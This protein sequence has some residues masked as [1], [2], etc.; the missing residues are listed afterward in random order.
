MDSKSMDDNGSQ[1]SGLEKEPFLLND[2][3][4][5]HRQ[6]A[7]SSTLLMAVWLASHII[8]SAILGTVFVLN[9]KANFREAGFLDKDRA[10]ANIPA[11]FG[12]LPVRHDNSKGP[13]VTCQSTG[14]PEAARQAG[15]RFDLFVNGWVPSPCFDGQKHDYFVEQ[16]DYY[17][18]VDKEKRQRIPQEKLLEGTLEYPELFVSFEEHYEHCRYLLNATKR[19][20]HNPNLGVLDVHMDEEHMN[21]CIDFLRESRDP[22]TVE[23]G[24]MA[25][26]GYRKC[27]LPRLDM[28]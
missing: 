5:K 12:G 18:W 26:F 1:W 21:H 13:Y 4:K 10:S 11:E 8:A 15:C 19:Y 9:I 2:G 6:R 28:A 23:K 24:V 3:V 16:H 17:F 27:F 20:A 22:Y 25:Y 14:G 7:C